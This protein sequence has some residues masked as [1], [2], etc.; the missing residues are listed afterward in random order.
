[1]CCHLPRAWSKPGDP[2]ALVGSRS[3]PDTGALTRGSYRN[4]YPASAPATTTSAIPRASH[5][6]RDERRRG[7]AARAARRPP[8]PAAPDPA[9][10]DPA[11]P[12]PA[13]PDPAGPDP[14]AGVM[15]AGGTGSSSSRA[16]KPCGGVGG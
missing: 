1:M 5:A 15:A 9:G 14:A 8:D 12:D 3:D 4:L 6:A 10:P 13:G 11:G 2:G 7:A 16:G